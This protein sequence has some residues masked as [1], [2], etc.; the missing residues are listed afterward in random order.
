MTQGHDTG[1]AAADLDMPRHF[2]D[3]RRVF[4]HAG[5]TI[6]NIDPSTEDLAGYFARGDATDIHAAVEAADRARR[7]PWREMTPAERGGV[8]FKLA[9]MVAAAASELAA[10]ETR[11]VGKPVKEAIGDIGGV[12]ATLRYN[13]GAADKLE[14]ASIPL[15]PK[16][17]DFTI[18]EPVGVTAHIVPWN[19][20]LGMAARSVAPALAAGC[21]VVLKPAEQSASSALRFAELAADAGLPPGVFN[22]VCGTGAEAGEPLVRHPLVRS[23][24]FTGSAVTGARIMATAS[25]NL[26][27]VVLELGGKNAVIVFADADLD[28]L[29]E[30]VADGAFGNSGQVCSSS[31]R[32]LCERSIA[33]ELAERL[34]ERARKI[35]IGRGIDD[36]DIG[37]LVSQAQYDKVTG[38]VQAALSARARLVTGGG[39]PKHLPR[40]FFIEPTI[41]ADVDPALPI[42]REEVFGPV[43]AITPFDRIDDAL[44]LANG[45]AYGLVA[46]IYTRDISRALTLAARIEAGSVWI[47]GWFIGGQQAPT[48]GIKNSG[49]G[50]ERGLPGLK[51]YVSIKNIGIRL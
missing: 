42:A 29:V 7:G 48:G 32:I 45:T 39:R 10:M 50:R 23:V 13:A 31:S 28:R 6:A 25:A 20:P 41:F 11:D 33:A 44:A 22:V 2:I 9:D 49:I 17:V 12:V 36:P 1:R 30:D 3:G 16:F 34:C 15:G 27:P 37:P 35:T 21:T 24:T 51:N 19:F 38:H 46:G 26:T 14:G 5:Q 4:A 8:L 43:L 18:L 47:N 40:G